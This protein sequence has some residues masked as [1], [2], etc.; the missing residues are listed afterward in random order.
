M[1]ITLT[2]TIVG[3]NKRELE[4]FSYTDYKCQDMEEDIDPENNF[5]NDIVDNCCYYTTDQYN[6]TVKVDNKLSII[7]FNSR[8]LNANFNSI[9]ARHGR[10]K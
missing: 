3:A 1:D 8:S 6:R 5:F 4:T 7:H 10:Q 2:P 9:K